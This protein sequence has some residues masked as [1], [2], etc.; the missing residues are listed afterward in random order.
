M[1]ICWRDYT[2]S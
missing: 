1:L 2:D